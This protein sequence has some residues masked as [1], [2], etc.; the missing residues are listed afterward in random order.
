MNLTNSPGWD[1]VS[2]W[3]PEGDRIAFTSNRDGNWEIYSM[4]P[5]GGDVRRLTN[6]PGFDGDPV[7]IRGTWIPAKV[8]DE[9][10]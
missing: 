6:S 5:A 9:T 1:A 3:S 8:D 10:R 2:S 4:D 7:W